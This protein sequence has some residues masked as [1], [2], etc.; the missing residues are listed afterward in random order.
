M[1]KTTGQIMAITEDEFHTLVKQYVWHRSLVFTA[2]FRLL[3]SYTLSRYAFH[4][5]PHI[6]LL[7]FF[8]KA[9]CYICFFEHKFKWL[10]NDAQ[11]DTVFSTKKF[12]VLLCSK[13]KTGWYR[14]HSFKSICCLNL[15]LH[16]S[17]FTISVLFKICSNILLKYISFIYLLFHMKKTSQ[18]SCL[19]C[20][21]KLF[22]LIWVLLRVHYIS[23]M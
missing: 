14:L 23:Y 7:F 8:Y 15:C 6:S 10:T 19:I 11:N 18:E 17:S 21:K 2:P 1:F 12:S 3:V 4:I 20:Q 9:R 16:F 5:S 22:W 13:R